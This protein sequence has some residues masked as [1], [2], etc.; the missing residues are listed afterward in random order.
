[1]LPLILTIIILVAFYSIYR[2]IKA[3]KKVNKLQYKR[4]MNLQNLAQ[5]QFNTDENGKEVATPVFSQGHPKQE[6]KQLIPAIVLAL[7]LGSLIYGML[8]IRQ[9]QN[10]KSHMQTTNGEIIKFKKLKKPKSKTPYYLLNLKFMD[11]HGKIH[12][13]RKN[14][15][16][17]PAMK[18]L[19]IGTKLPITYDPSSPVKTASIVEA[20]SKKVLIQLT[21][22][23]LP[24][25][26]FILVLFSIGLFVRAH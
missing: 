10:L 24:F 9:V 1:M 25:I 20:T 16:K 3:I 15:K 5:M 21:T 19:K 13:I 11:V 17:I 8:Q 4:K 2:L 7:G 26:G 14:V 12:Q 23:V 18:S 22:F 6:R